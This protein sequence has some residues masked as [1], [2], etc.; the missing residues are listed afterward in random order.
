MRFAELLTQAE[1]KRTHEASL[2]V[3]ET[4]GILA[5]YAGAREVFK[6]HG[7]HVDESTGL[8]KFPADVVEKYVAMAPSSFTFRGRDPQFDRTIPDPLCS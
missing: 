3:L 6:K 8:V 4:V 7:C 5:H 2:E 1:V